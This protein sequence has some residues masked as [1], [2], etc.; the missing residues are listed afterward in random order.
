VSPQ[1]DYPALFK[2]DKGV[3]LSIVVVD[4]VSILELIAKQLKIVDNRTSL[5]S[6]CSKSF[7]CFLPFPVQIAFCRHCRHDILIFLPA[8]HMDWFAAKRSQ[9]QIFSPTSML[10]K[11]AL[12]DSPS[13]YVVLYCLFL[14]MAAAL[15]AFLFSQ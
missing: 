12:I 14:T 9:H 5:I 2:P 13:I 8:C 4:H 7:F 15:I 11:R 1:I 10:T 3:S 6:V